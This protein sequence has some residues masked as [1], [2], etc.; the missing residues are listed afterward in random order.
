MRSALSA[1]ESIDLSKLDQEVA[2]KLSAISEKEGK[3]VVLTATMASP[4]TQ[5]VI[6]GFKEKFGNVEHVIFDAVSEDAALNAF[7]KMYGPR[8]LPN[9]DLAKAD[10]IVSVAAD[11]LGDW[12]GG[13]FEAGYAKGRKPKGGKNVRVIFNLNQI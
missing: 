7:E 1:G 3:I 4:S 13:G 12:Q 8:A 10:V 9:Y 2:D 11:F 5:Q 6:N